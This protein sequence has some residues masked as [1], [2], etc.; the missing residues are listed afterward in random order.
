LSCC[1]A[2]STNARTSP[3]VRT[4][5]YRKYRA[6][7]KRAFLGALRTSTSGYVTDKP[8]TTASPTPFERLAG[9][10]LVQGTSSLLLI[11]CDHAFRSSPIGPTFPPPFVCLVLRRF[12]RRGETAMTGK[13]MTIGTVRCVS[14]C[15]AAAPVTPGLEI[16]DSGFAL[17]AENRGDH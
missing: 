2:L 3:F 8:P 14:S 9:G 4:N 11:A 1:G 15:L 13:G 12:T 10:H 5:E 7:K 17:F 6:I 16:Q